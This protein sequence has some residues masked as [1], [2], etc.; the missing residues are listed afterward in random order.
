M[1]AIKYQK[2]SLIRLEDLLRRRKTNL[3]NFIKERGIVTYQTLEETCSRLGVTT[4]TPEAFNEC[5]P[6]YV[7][8]PAAGVVVVPPL[9]VVKE[10]TG[11]K[12][13]LV[14]DEFVAIPPAQLEPEADPVTSAL[15][16]G[17]E[18]F[19]VDE[20]SRLSAMTSGKRK[21]KIA[22]A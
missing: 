9:D 10:S 16:A 15:A 4:P 2:K 14:D 8:D 13:T 6:S 11:E 22:G 1:K 5:V 18:V 3:K 17:A 12:D 21:R 19:S 7:S 20:E